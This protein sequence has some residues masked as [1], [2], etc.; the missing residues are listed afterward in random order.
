MSF[1]HVLPGV[2]LFKITN[3]DQIYEQKSF[4]WKKIEKRFLD[5]EAVVLGTEYISLLDLIT[6]LLSRDSRDITILLS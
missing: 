2:A 6:K 1:R 5:L 4:F 3:F